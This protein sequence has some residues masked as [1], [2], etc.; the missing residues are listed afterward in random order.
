MLNLSIWSNRPMSKFIRALISLLVASLP[1]FAKPSVQGI[2]NFYKVDER[3]YRGAQPTDDGFRYLA[4]LG[5]KTVVDLRESDARS[6]REAQVV[7]A[8]G[9]RYINIPMTGLTPPS[10]ADITRILALLEDGNSGGVFVHCK[11][12][13]DRTGAV[14]AAYRIDRDHWD[15]YRAL[16]E[17]MSCGIAL[18]Q[19]PR[20]NYIRTFQA[21]T[22][23]P[24]VQVATAVLTAQH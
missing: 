4:N 1:A 21:R 6:A 2:Q 18:F 16:K 3:V 17:A 10:E 14:I 11:R 20:M 7:T 22:N 9:M 12:G 13:A 24:G 23:A 19:L 8:L 15:N 5:L